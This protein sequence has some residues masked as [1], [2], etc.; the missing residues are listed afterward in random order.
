MKSRK[1]RTPG[2]ADAVA[3]AGSRK[4]QEKVFQPVAV[5]VGGIE[6]GTQTCRLIN[7]HTAFKITALHAGLGHYEEHL[8]RLLAHTALKRIQW[9]NLGRKVV[10]FRTIGK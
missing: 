4:T 2:H 6:V 5:R 9:I 7:P 10:T 1:A 8:R 3:R